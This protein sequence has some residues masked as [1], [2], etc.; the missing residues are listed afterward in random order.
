[1]KKNDKEGDRRDP[2]H[3]HANPLMSQVCSILSLAIYLAT[4]GFDESGMNFP[5]G[6]QSGWYTKISRRVMMIEDVK[7]EING[8]G[9]CA[10]DFGS[11]SAR[12]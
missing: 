5:G 9:L 8:I 2:R 7:N 1:M 11:H 12:K 3:V 4:F 10:A 6:N